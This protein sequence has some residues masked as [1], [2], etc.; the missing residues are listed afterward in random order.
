MKRPARPET[1]EDIVRARAGRDQ[2]R[3]GRAFE[4]RPAK[5]QG[6]LKAAVL[7]Q[8]HAGRD[9]RRPRQM[10]G[11]PNGGVPVEN[12]RASCRGRVG[13]YVW[14]SGVAVALKKKTD[15]KRKYRERY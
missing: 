7:I 9:P 10:V 14:S 13:Q 8:E 5:A 12:G 6:S 2:L 15:K 4:V 3:F 1:L 11:A